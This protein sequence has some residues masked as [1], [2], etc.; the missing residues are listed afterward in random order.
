MI[1]VAKWIIAWPCSLFLHVSNSI[2]ESAGE[3]LHSA[4]ICNR[5]RN[6]KK[7]LLENIKIQLKGFEKKKKIRSLAPEID[8]LSIGFHSGFF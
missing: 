7:C 3:E 1:Y 2:Q 8:K 5:Y 4:T 6:S